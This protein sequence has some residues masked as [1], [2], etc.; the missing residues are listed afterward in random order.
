[1][2]KH[3]K[4]YTVAFI[5]IPLKSPCASAKASATRGKWTLSCIQPVLLIN[6]NCPLQ[7][8][9]GENY[10]NKLF[11]LLKSISAEIV[12]K[13]FCRFTKLCTNNEQQ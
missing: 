2:I 5:F 10:D 8:V 9:G 4:Q 13:K 11:T 6:N 12:F 1:M 3:E 7:G